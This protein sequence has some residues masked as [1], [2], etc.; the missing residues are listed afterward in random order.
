MFNIHT[1]IITLSY[2]APSI[3]IKFDIVFINK[4]LMIDHVLPDGHPRDQM[5]STAF[6]TIIVGG[7]NEVAAQVI[8]VPIL[9]H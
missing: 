1:L 3:L 4:L 8:Y 6:N 7:S 5:I 2:T 9:V